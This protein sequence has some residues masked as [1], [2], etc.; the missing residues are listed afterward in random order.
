LFPS[1]IFARIASDL[2]LSLS[3]VQLADQLRKSVRHALSHDI[4]V[5]GAQLMPD[6]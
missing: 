5:H 3:P 1:F 6:P 4:V 2:G